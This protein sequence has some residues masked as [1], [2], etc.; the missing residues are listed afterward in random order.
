MQAT[1]INASNELN[2]G[3]LKLIALTPEQLRLCLDDPARLEKEL[4]VA[5]S[6]DLVSEAVRRASRIKLDK[7]SVVPAEAHPW[8]TYWLLVI[9][10]EDLGAGLLGFKGEPNGEGEVEIGY[11]IDPAH[12]SRGYTTEAVRALIAWALAHPNCRSVV[13]GTRK[14]NGASGRVLA[15]VGMR[16]DRETEDTVVWRT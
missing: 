7:M 14:G 13:A 2:A 6:P 5:L 1:S 11:G 15:K 3:R 16:V 10:A 9:T 12:R 4:G 8:Y